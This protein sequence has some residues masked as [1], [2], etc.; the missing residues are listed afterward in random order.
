MPLIF[1]EAIV[2]QYVIDFSVLLGQRFVLVLLHHCCQHLTF[3]FR[4]PHCQFSQTSIKLL[5]ILMMYIFEA[6]EG[7]GHI[8]KTYTYEILLALATLHL[9]PPS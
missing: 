2:V 6:N 7:L 3:M 8:V 4:R 9:M 5:C 1:K